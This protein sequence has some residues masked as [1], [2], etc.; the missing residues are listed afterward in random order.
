MKF[1]LCVETRLIASLRRFWRNKICVCLFVCRDAKFCVST[2]SA[3]AHIICICIF[4]CRDAKF[5]VS[6]A[7]ASPTPHNSYRPKCTSSVLISDG[8]TPGILDA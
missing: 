4:M 6:T 7:S 3:S 2:A 1:V 8:L 5:C